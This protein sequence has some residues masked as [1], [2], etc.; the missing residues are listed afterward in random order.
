MNNRN[1]FNNKNK[2]NK[3]HSYGKKRN[4]NYV[5]NVKSN[6][7]NN[8][9][10]FNNNNNSNWDQC[11][12]WFPHEVNFSKFRI[13]NPK[14]RGDNWI[15][16]ITYDNQT[17]RFQT[18]RVK[19]AF[20]LKGWSF[21]DDDKKKKY[22][23]S[24]SLPEDDNL[25]KNL[26]SL[27]EEIDNT[28]KNTFVSMKP[29]LK[30]YT[31]INSIRYDNK[32]NK[33]P[34][35][36]RSNLVSNIDT[37]KAK[38]TKNKIPIKNKKIDYIT[39]NLIRKNNEVILILELRPCWVNSKEKKWGVSYKCHSIDL[40]EEI[41]KYREPEYYYEN[42]NENENNNQNNIPMVLSENS[43][44]LCNCG[45]KEFIDNCTSCQNNSSNKNLNSTII[46]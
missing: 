34:P 26:I 3:N 7:N 17:F 4:T 15:T 42:E 44:Q 23:I 11:K 6:V 18:P 31:F 5:R 16:E 21:N 12:V 38:I 14:N 45:S 22:S 40:Q 27:I 13:E 30:N 33:Y 35:H 32:Y 41:I 9:N 10:N 37:F 24:I 36:L 8:N 46:S 29:E 19:V 28:T 39:K 20:A 2:A 1:Y 25:T 43:K